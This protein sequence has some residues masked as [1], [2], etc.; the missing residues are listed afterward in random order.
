MSLDDETVE[1]GRAEIV[2]GFHRRIAD[3]WDDVIERTG[4][5]VGEL[6]KSG[7]VKNVAIIYIDEETAVF[8]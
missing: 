3:W 7:K 1:G 8:R 5:K 6:K 4:D 2:P